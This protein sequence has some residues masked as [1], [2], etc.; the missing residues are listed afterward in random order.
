M[1]ITRETL[2][3]LRNFA[4]ING[5]IKVE[6][7]SALKTI[8]A[9]RNVLAEAE[10]TEAFPKE[11]CIYNLSEFLN[12]VT[13]FDDA[14]LE[15]GD[16]AVTIS[17]EETR[18]VYK[19]SSPSIIVAPEK[20]INLPDEPDV[21]FDLSAEDLSKLWRGASAVNGDTINITTNG[22]QVDLEALD[23]RTTV[24]TFKLRL[25]VPN[26]L[27]SGTFLLKRANMAL[28]GG[29]GYNVSLWKKGISR[30]AGKDIPVKYYVALE[31]NAGE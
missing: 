21:V 18:L 22:N 24:N 15:F 5:N 17:T 4:S 1:K 29:T 30:F 25:T 23:L 2:A 6:A 8:S 3:I 11:F 13:L 9:A 10:I 19:Y 28:I 16:N 7:G 20:P 26:E 14:D 27:Q 31:M 12:C